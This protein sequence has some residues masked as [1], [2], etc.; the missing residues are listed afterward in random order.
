V[1]ADVHAPVH[2]MLQRFGLLASLGNE[3]IFPTVADAVEAFRKDATLAPA[4]AQ[5]S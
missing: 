3:R 1:L 2:A 5:A 4:A